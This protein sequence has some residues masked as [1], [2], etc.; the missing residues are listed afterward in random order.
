MSIAHKRA[1]S[2]DWN[3]YPGKT[4]KPERCRVMLVN[5]SDDNNRKTFQQKKLVDSK[6][7]RRQK[8]QTRSFTVAD[9]LTTSHYNFFL[10]FTNV[11]QPVALPPF[12]LYGQCHPQINVFKQKHVCRFTRKT[13]HVSV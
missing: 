7:A 1:Q 2:R 3:K 11:N 6:A 8:K 13:I 12:E 4:I 5:I 9:C 10:I